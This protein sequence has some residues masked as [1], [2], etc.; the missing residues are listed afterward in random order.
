MELALERPAHVHLVRGR[1]VTGR[2]N[3]I[4]RNVTAQLKRRGQNDRARV[5]RG[6][7]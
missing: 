2:H 1:L 4:V 6:G 5:T 3:R 7:Y